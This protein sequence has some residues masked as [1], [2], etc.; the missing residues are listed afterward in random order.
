M[1]MGKRVL[2]TGGSGMVGQAIKDVVA[3]GP[4]NEDQWTF[5]GSRDAD[6]RDA[7]Q[8]AALF[9]RVQPTHVIH[10]AAFVGGLFKNMEHKVEFW[11][12]NVAMNNNVL[13]QCKVHKVALARNVCLLGHPPP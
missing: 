9:D 4:R 6:L 8:T 1:A 12:Y 3:S 10:L 7:Q 13:E 2:V 11:N 5:A